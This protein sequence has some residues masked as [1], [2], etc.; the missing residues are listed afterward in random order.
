M[1]HNTSPVDRVYFLAIHMVNQVHKYQ[2]F[3]HFAMNYQLEAIMTQY[4]R[5]HKL[6]LMY[7][8]VDQ[9]LGKTYHSINKVMSQNK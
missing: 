3:H 1:N 8:H 2:L 6:S 4:Y 5:N 9:A 7:Q